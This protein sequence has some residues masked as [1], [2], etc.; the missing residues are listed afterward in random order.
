LYA[1]AN[2]GGPTRAGF[3]V[4]RRTGKAVVRNRVKR[5]LRE[6]VRALYSRLAP[7]TDLVWIA[8]PPSATADYATLAGAVEH[9]L[10]RARLLRDR[11]PGPRGPGVAKQEPRATPRPQPSAGSADPAALTT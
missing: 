3:V 5:R 6:A 10:R 11:P 2:E 8:R 9:L 4:G 1:A 7:G